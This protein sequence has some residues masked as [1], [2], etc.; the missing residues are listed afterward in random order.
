VKR[1][2][3]ILVAAGDGN[4]F[5]GP[6]PKQ[7]LRLGGEQILTRSLR[8]IAAA[9]VDSVV[10]VT[11]RSWVAESEAIVRSESLAI[12]ASVVVGGATRNEST[13]NGLRS[14]GADADDV[15]VVHDAVRPL[16]PLVVIRRAI[17]PVAAGI[18]DATDT[19]IASDDTLVVLRG[20]EVV[21]VP[22]RST[23]RRSQTPQVFR[24]QVLERAL[25]AAADAD[26]LHATDDCGLVFRYVPGAR[27]LAVAGDDV[28]LKITT[29]L[30]LL[31]AEQLLGDALS[32]A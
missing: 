20:D 14:L 19:V 21:D 12:P 23:Y 28:N 7:F 11:N 31:I 10:I 13:R 3:A 4:R 15:I 32:R 16:V 26:D 27:L 9:G 6:I 5:G 17:E 29:R 18:A 8:V 1:V 22:D 30:D 24:A 2:H 25:D